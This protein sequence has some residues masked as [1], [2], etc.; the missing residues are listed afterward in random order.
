MSCCGQLRTLMREPA[1]QPVN[2]E[3]STPAPPSSPGPSSDV[4]LRYIGGA[5]AVVTGP[6]TRKQYAFSPLRPTNRIDP[7]D[8][9]PMLRTRLFVRAW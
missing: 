4:L 1:R 7:R 5:G 8:V 3:G 6:A 9:G 2:V